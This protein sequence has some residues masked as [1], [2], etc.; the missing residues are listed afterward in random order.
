MRRLHEA[1]PSNADARL[2]VEMFCYSVRKGL[3][4]M[5]AA[6]DGVNLIVFTGGIGENDPEV[7][8]A[9]GGGLSWLGVGLDE[10]QNRAAADPISDPTSRCAV[11][12]LASQE[13]EQIARHTSQLFDLRETPEHRM[14]TK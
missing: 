4:A 6:L 7:R 12:V 5:I 11:R 2:A 10:A 8:A 14:A 3:A 9:I 1:A 13:D